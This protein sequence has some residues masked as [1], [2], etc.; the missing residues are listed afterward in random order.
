MYFQLYKIY[1]TIA[2]P[3]VLLPYKIKKIKNLKNIYCL[4][5]LKLN[6]AIEIL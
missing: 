5:L 2:L 4:F 1:Y 3:C 6:L